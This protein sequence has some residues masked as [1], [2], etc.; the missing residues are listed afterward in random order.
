[1]RVLLLTSA[2]PPVAGGA[3]SYAQVVAHALT[4]AG[5]EVLVVTDARDATPAAPEAHPAVVSVD[6]YWSMVTDPAKLRWEQMAFAVLSDL[7]PLV[8]AFGP[9]VVLTNNLETAVLGRMIA[10]TLGI[11]LVTAFHEHAPLDEPFG[12]GKLRLAYQ[13]IAPDR[14]LCGSRFYYDRALTL[15]GPERAQL[16]YHGVATEDFATAQPWDGRPNVPEHVTTIVCIGRLKARKGQTVLLE[17]LRRLPGE[18]LADT[19]VVLAGSVSSASADYRAGLLATIE[20]TSLGDRVALVEDVTLDEVP[21]LLAMA[22]LAVVPSL[23]EGLGFT[24]LEAF[25]AEVPVVTSRVPGIEEVLVEGGLAW[26]FAP[27]D[28][29]ALAEALHRA[30]TDPDRGAQQAEHA[31]RVVQE[32]FSIDR[33]AAETMRVLGEAVD[34]A[35]RRGHDALE[36]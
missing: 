9:D 22:D 21:K 35:R 33:M 26:E 19:T 28:P 13:R 11:A 23:E 2:Y 14:V 3:E 31:R 32:R 15:V 20:Q 6:G 34:E 29:A 12:I 25:A 7:E 4:R 5:A 30:L 27:G 36:S 10:D 1:M 24:V 17:A 16:V 18:L 8:A